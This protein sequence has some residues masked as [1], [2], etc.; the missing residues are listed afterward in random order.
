MK[1]ILEKKLLGDLHEFEA[2]YDR[3]RPD[4]RTYGLWRESPCPAVVFFMTWVHTCSISRYN[5]SVNLN[6]SLPIS[7]SRNPIQ[8]L[9]I[10]LM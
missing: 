6:T 1:Q 10:I 4:P 8:L 9:M 5:Y 3:Y 7:A 2:H